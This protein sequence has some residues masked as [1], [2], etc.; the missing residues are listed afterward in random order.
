MDAIMRSKTQ[1]SKP[2]SMRNVI[3][4]VCAVMAFLGSIAAAFA[5]RQERDFNLRGYIDATQTQELPFRI[6]RLGVNAD[7]TQYTPD[8]LQQNLIWMEQA[9]I[10][11]IRQEFRWD[12]IERN[13]GEFDWIQSDAIVNA[14][15]LHPKLRLVAVLLHTPVWARTDQK[16]SL[17]T[18]PPDDPALFGEFSRVFTQRYGNS[19]DFYQ[20]WDEPNIALGWG[21]L[22]PRAADYTALLQSA[23]Q[24]I[25]NE[26]SNATVIAAGLAPTVETG[27]L[28][29]RDDIYLH[30]LYANQA[31][32]YMDAASGKAY[33]FNLP[34][35]D[36]TV[37]VDVLNFSRIIALREI[38]VANGEANKPLWIS[39]WGWNSL[40]SDR[41]GDSSPWG[42]VT[43]ELRS[44][45]TQDALDRAEREWP[46]LGGMI[47]QTWQPIA[48]ENNPIWG[49]SLIGQDGLPGTLWDELAA[50]QTINSATNGL[51]R[52]QNPFTSYNGIWTFSDIGADIGWVEDSRLEFDF[53]GQAI[54]L[55]L[56]QDNYVAYL[57]PLIDRQ[58]AN[59]P[60]R[61]A[62]GNA[63]ILLTS[64]SLMPEISLVPVAR[65][66]AENQHTLHVIAD[67][68]VP[69]EANN[70]WPLV[71][72]AVSSG[73]LTAPYN[74]Q[75]AIGWVTATIA[76]ISAMVSGIG[77]NWIGITRPIGRVWRWMNQAGQVIFG[78]FTSLALLFGMLIT[79]GDSTPAVFR[80]D[81]VQLV[82]SVLTSGFILLQPGFILTLIAALVLLII[83]F[84]RLEIGLM[85]IIFWAPFFLFPVELYRFAFPLAEIVLWISV[86][87]WILRLLADAGKTKKSKT[88]QRFNLVTLDY[89]VLAWVIIGFVSLTWAEKKSPAITE[90]RT[91]IL[92]SVLFYAILRTI[93]FKRN[94]ILLLVDALVAAGLAVAVIGLFQYVRGEAIITAE[95]GAGRLAS[96]YGSPNNVGLLLGRCIPFAFA[97]LL[98]PIDRNRRIL[99]GI[100]LATMGTAVVLS[101]SAGAL[102]IG[103]P[104]AVAAVLLLRF[105]QRAILPLFGLIL[106]FVVGLML[107]QTSPRFSRLFT[108]SEG[109]NF[110]RLRVW[111]STLNILADYPITGLGLDQ[112]LYAFRGQYILPDAW[113]EPT[114]SHPHNILLDFW[115]RLGIFGVSILIAF[116]IVFWRNARANYRLYRDHDQILFAITIGLTGSMINL[117]AHGLV[118]NSVYVLDLATIFMLLMG[119][120]L[121]LTNT[122]AID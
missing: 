23:Y 60:P 22:P 88:T 8:E 76:F 68:L 79:F 16:P 32:A 48:E 28:N 69:D 105:R 46:W 94:T 84:N 55:L 77:L 95:A 42:E 7:L 71:G 29:F 11:W 40:S 96:V 59:A 115:V 58:Q 75:I 18:A 99:S 83:I 101:Q 44:A 51:F 104:T 116:I 24:A 52:P 109:T 12:E 114:L 118:D 93:P 33:G 4:F 15:N 62:A 67:E 56:R 92:Q 63:Y 45:Y 50:R 86:A 5:T 110:Y 103:I 53:T 97:F 57:Y 113:Q 121:R 30:Q 41:Q 49:F 107:V 10:K 34:P 14:V 102:F 3:I 35:S 80:R 21:G 87:A 117:L 73:D 78:A 100:V 25:H 39:H 98:S 108:L 122:S 31:S 106:L 26:D 19:I 72:F 70:R 13:Q 1:P 47:L 17:S 38:M 82:L 66:L 65:N 119:L 27:P 74:R 43:Q 54:S 9:H 37:S 20:V 64:S 89:V 90:L 81:S 2:A 91:L 111:Q 36:R 61:D 120:C 6:A 112:F 85:L